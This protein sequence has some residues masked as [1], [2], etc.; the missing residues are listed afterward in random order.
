MLYDVKLTTNNVIGKFLFFG[1]AAMVAAS[2][3]QNFTNLNNDQQLDADSRLRAHK[4]LLLKQKY[5]H[6]QNAAEQKKQQ[7]GIASTGVTVAL[8]NEEVK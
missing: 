7:R 8:H 6:A 3:F 2:C 5:Y 4:S 1:F